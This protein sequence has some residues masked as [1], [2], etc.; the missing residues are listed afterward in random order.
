MTFSYIINEQAK[1]GI[2]NTMLFTLALPKMK[3][4]YKS[5]K[6]CA[7]CV[8]KNYLLPVGMKSNIATFEH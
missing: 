8:R 2:K 3:H 7:F 6:I 4:M 1:F 5:N